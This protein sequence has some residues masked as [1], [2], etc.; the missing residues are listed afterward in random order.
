MASRRPS[1]PAPLERPD[2][3]DIPSRA[4]PDVSLPVRTQVFLCLELMHTLLLILLGTSIATPGPAIAA[5][6]ALGLPFAGRRP[7]MPR[8]RYASR[9]T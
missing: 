5:I 4:L 2:P 1:S 7:I 6:A 3:Q 8:S 9:Y